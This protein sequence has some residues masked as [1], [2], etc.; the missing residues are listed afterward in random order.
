MRS[1]G[2]QNIHFDGDQ[3]GGHASEPLWNFVGKAML[4]D[5]IASVLVSEVSEPFD[6]P[7]EIPPLFFGAPGVP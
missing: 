5:D 6:H 7:G 4:Q 3:L 2:D 1:D